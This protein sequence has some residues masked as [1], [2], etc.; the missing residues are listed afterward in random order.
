M[1][2]PWNKSTDLQLD[3][4]DTAA[5]ADVVSPQP[6]ATSTS[7]GQPLMLAMTSLYVDSN[8]PPT[9]IP[10]GDLDELTDD[11][12]ERGVLQA[13][14]SLSQTIPSQLKSPCKSRT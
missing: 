3:L 14:M 2:L 11:I 8:N 9:E 7:A 1:R 4:L 6:P 10:E 12:R 13:T 5:V